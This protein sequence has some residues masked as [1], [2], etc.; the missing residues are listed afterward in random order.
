MST[1]NANTNAALTPLQLDPKRYFWLF[2]AFWGLVPLVFMYA[3]Y[4]TGQG[5]WIWGYFVFIF[6]VMPRLDKIMGHSSYNPPESEF[7][8]MRDDSYYKWLARWTAITPY[9]CHIAGAWYIS[10]HE[11]SLLVYFG[12]A[13]AAGW[14]M[15]L[16]I[17]A[18]HEVGHK[19]TKIDHFFASLGL[20]ACFMGHFRIE[21]NNGHHIQVATPED[22]AT[23][24]MGQNFYEFVLTE[25]P[26]GF[27]RA[28]RIE[29]TRLAKK[30]ISAFSLKNEVFRNALLSILY[31]TIVVYAFGLLVLPFLLI[32]AFMGN[33][34]LSSANYI[35]HYGLKRAKLDNGKYERCQPHHSWN[36]N[37]FLSNLLVLHLERHSDHHAHAQR[38]YQCLRH[39]DDVPQLPSGYLPM[40]FLA[41]YPPKWF[42]VMDKMVADWAG[43]DMNKVMI[44]EGMEEEMFAKW[45][46]P[47]EAEA[48]K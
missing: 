24:R 8:R 44:K 21:H 11:P 27:A 30:G 48:A 5:L 14:A 35:E 38:P 7:V 3:A 6:G 34:L 25:L 19:S 46:N 41:W 13:W 20:A 43:G 37:R 23:A 9:F 15:G 47:K 1:V 12:F 28:W 29:R 2:A 10:T 31:Y 22:T 42:K 26:G 40:F 32:A 18:A 45:H 39:F 4:A 33:L 17:N 16:A 36:S